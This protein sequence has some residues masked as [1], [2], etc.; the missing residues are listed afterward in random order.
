L[1]RSGFDQ[2]LSLSSAILRFGLVKIVAPT[3]IEMADTGNHCF[4]PTPSWFLSTSPPNDDNAL[5]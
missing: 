3:G 2:F 1:G 5:F 4:W